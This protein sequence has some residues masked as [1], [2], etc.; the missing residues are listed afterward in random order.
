MKKLS[1]MEKFIVRRV[2]FYLGCIAIIIAPLFIVNH[3]YIIK[4]LKWDDLSFPLLVFSAF[5][6]M[7]AFCWILNIIKEKYSTIRRRR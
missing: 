5:C 1:R 2:I 6:F 7:A 4:I 3:Y